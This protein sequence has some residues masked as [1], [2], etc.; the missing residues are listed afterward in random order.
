MSLGGWMQSSLT[1]EHTHTVQRYPYSPVG[2][3]G[4]LLCAIIGDAGQAGAGRR[5]GG[6][7]SSSARPVAVCRIATGGRQRE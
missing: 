1:C 7:A 2:E 3:P 6:A 4:A 5:G